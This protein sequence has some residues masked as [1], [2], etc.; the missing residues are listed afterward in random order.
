[1]AG[2][3]TVAVL[4]RRGLAAELGKRG[5]QSDL[6]LFHA[7]RDG[8]A[9]T[10]VEPTQYPERFAPLLFALSMADR[11]ILAVGELSREVAEVVATVDLFDTPID[12]WCGP[13]VGEAELRRAFQ[14]TRV[15]ALPVQPL[16]ANRMRE[17]IG[18]WSAS[19]A[20]TGPANVPIDHAFPVKGVGAVAL[21]IVRGAPVQAHERLRL[22][23]GEKTVEVR[24]IQVHDVDVRSASPGERVGLALRGVDAE[25][26]ARGQVLAPDGS[27]SVGQAFRARIERRC[28]YYRGRFEPG[29]PLQLLVGL[30]LVPARLGRIE[31][32]ALTL[33]AD[34][35]VAFEPGASARL[36]DPSAASG[37]RIAARVRISGPSEG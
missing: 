35:P 6:T 30:Q 20:T 31:G 27:L 15:G 5:T 16:D 12:L 28:P 17:E 25:E 14:G 22:Y 1:M 2:S 24:S 7:V 32:E 29:A 10:I 36:I 33:E 34:R 8:H 4:G 26:L 3:I 37:P 19:D 21:G 13:G 11:A 9:A 23:P 18:A